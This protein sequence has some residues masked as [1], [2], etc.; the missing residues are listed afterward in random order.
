[1]LQFKR[2]YICNIGKST[3]KTFMRHHPWQANLVDSTPPTTFPARLSPSRLEKAAR[4]P[5]PPL[6]RLNIGWRPKILMTM[7]MASL[8]EKGQE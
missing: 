5:F 7:A 2:T 3:K 1:L 4:G 8:E 6:A